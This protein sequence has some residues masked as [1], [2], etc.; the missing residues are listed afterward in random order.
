MKVLD[1]QYPTSL[2]KIED[3][4]NDNVDIIV[5][6]EDGMAYT[7]VV[8][9]PQNFNWYMNKEE[10]YYLPPSP[11]HIVVKSVTEKNILAAVEAFAEGDAY[12]LKVF[13]LLGNR[14]GIFDMSNITKMLDKIKKNNDNI[15]DCE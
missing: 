8:S 9:T 7:L 14:S 10:T 6:L 5:T 4:N 1:I 15:L 3:I 11:P 12:W 13:Y 2:D